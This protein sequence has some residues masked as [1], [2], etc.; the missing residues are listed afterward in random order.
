MVV[1]LGL[2]R[3][4]RPLLGETANRRIALGENVLAGIAVALLLAEDWLPLGY[5]VGVGAN[6]VFVGGLILAVMG[7]F[8]L[9][10]AAYPTILRVILRH[11]AVFLVA[12]AAIVVFGFTALLGFDRVVSFL[13]ESV[14][15]S[16]LA[17]AAA[18][19][20]PGF[21]REYMPPFDEGSFLFMPTT[22]PHASI[23]EVLTTLS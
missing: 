5:R 13:P 16:R 11:K 15:S 8:R 17:V 10:E 9:F 21:G 4:A 22:M 3:L 6:V 18:R 19:A 14:R 1:A 23:G 7:T 12:P 20:L 2:Y